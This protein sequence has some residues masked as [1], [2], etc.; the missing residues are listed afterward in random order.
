ML[1]EILVSLFAVDSFRLWRRATSFPHLAQRGRALQ[2]PALLDDYHIL[3][4]PGVQVPEDVVWSAI[5]WADDEGVLVVDLIPQGLPAR[6]VLGLLNQAHPIDYAQRPFATGVSAG[7][8]VLVHE[9]I[10]EFSPEPDLTE[11]PEALKV[12][13]WI[14][15]AQGLKRFAPWESA[16]LVIEGWQLTSHE[17]RSVEGRGEGWR[18]I[19]STLF[20][21]AFE[22]GKWATPILFAMVTWL[23]WNDLVSGIIVLLAWMLQPICILWG[24]PFE[25]NQL[26]YGLLRPFFELNDWVKQLGPVSS[27]QGHHHADDLRETYQNDIQN[28]TERF[29]HPKKS[30][31][32]LCGE[33]ELTLHIEV[34]DQYQGKPGIFRLDR[35]HHCGHIFQ[36]PQLNLEGLSFYYRDFYDGLGEKGMDLVFGA[37]EQSYRQRV[38]MIRAHGA[39]RT[40]LDV[41]GGHGHFALIAK[42]LLPQTSFDVLDLSESVEIAEHRGWCRKG[43]RGLFPDYASSLSGQYDGISM[44]HYLEHVPDP[45]IEL[46]AAAIVLKEGGLLMIEIPDPDSR[47]GKWLRGIWLPWFQ[48]QHL[49]LLNTLNLTR[50]LNDRGFEVCEVDRREAHQSVDLFFAVLILIQRIAPDPSPPW[51]PQRSKLMVVG[52]QIW[53]ALIGLTFLPLLVLG[54]GLDRLLRPILARPNFSNTLRVLAVKSALEQD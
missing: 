3:S 27:E 51:A 18:E 7:I 34:A 2:A 40:W 23:A 35:C 38:A 15:H 32:P 54:A 12:K 39:P 36:N 46:D 20:G 13:R 14:E 45:L 19:A 8:A 17:L 43:M 49:H 29:F 10:L 31:C 42:H 16:R 53:R 25:A 22:Q 47:I 41:G 24:G 11:E 37:S 33:H 30:A 9:S 1:T 6:R 26:P 28:G 52:M 21:S 4:A 48:P 50:L 5:K 44:S